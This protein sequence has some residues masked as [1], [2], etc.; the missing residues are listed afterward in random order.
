L[1]ASLN[2]R[3]RSSFEDDVTLD[4]PKPISADPTNPKSRA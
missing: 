3:A 1:L 4:E 2:A